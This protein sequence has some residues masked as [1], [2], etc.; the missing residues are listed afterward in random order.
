MAACVHNT[1]RWILL[2][3][4]KRVL[5]HSPSPS[6][7]QTPL[8]PFCQI[9]F[10]LLLLIHCDR[11]S[12]KMQ[13]GPLLLS[14]TILFVVG[15]FIRAIATIGHCFDATFRVLFAYHLSSSMVNRELSKAL[16]W[17]SGRRNESLIVAIKPG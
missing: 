10:W 9:L 4:V 7:W 17:L 15:D 11:I 6:V 2:L 1:F 3:Q 16:R 14:Y 5:R 8:L 12:D 13:L